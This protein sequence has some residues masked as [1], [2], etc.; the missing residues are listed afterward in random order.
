MGEHTRYR[1]RLE[2]GTLFVEG[3]GDEWLEVGRMDDIIALLGGETYTVEYTKKQASAS[4]IDTDQDNTITVDIRERLSEMTFDADFVED[5]EDAS[6]E[7]IGEAEYPERTEYF[8][9]L[10]TDILESA[11]KGVEESGEA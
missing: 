10:L 3:E 5:I 11:G 9:E 1:T 2:D 4:W 7:T 6:P 8:A